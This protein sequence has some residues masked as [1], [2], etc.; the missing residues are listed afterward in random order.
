MPV[1]RNQGNPTARTMPVTRRLDPLG[2]R[3]SGNTVDVEY[4]GGGEL[5]L[6]SRSVPGVQYNFQQGVAVAVAEEDA[7][8][9]LNNQRNFR[10]FEGKIESAGT[11]PPM[12]RTEGT[13]Q[14]DNKPAR[15]TL[16]QRTKEKREADELL[17]EQEEEAAAKAQEQAR[18]QT[19]GGDEGDKETDKDDK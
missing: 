19:Q 11:T 1:A 2:N 10:K 9:L 3:Y 12:A 7:A 17:K 8:R 5:S 16:L 15:S 4:I 14:G 13:E 6:R 18:A